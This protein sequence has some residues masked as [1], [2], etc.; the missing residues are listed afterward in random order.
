M[1]VDHT[2]WGFVEFLSPLGQVMHIFGRLTL[3]IMCFFIAEGYRHTSRLSKY[4]DRMIG[5]ALIAII[6]FYL[7]F[8]EEYEYRQNIIFDLL[9]ALLAL[10]VMEKETL[11]KPIRILLVGVLLCIS[12]TIGG[13]V[14]MPIVYVLVFYYNDTFKKKTFWFC[15]YTCLMEVILFTAIV[16]N[17]KYHFSHY[18][19]TIQ[20]R[21]YLFG[22][23]LALI[24]LYF[25]NGQKGPV[26][27]SEK[28][29]KYFFYFF[30]PAHFLVLYGIK[31]IANVTPQSGYIFAHFV[32]LAIAC[33]ILIYVFMQPVSRAQVGVIFFVLSGIMYIYGFILEITTWEV[34]SVYT[35]TK[36]QYFG[37]IFVMISITY[38]IQELTHI[39]IPRCIYAA[40]I[41]VSVFV[42]YCLFTYRSNGL[43]YK[44]ISINTTAGPFPRMEVNGYGPV[45]YL[46]VAYCALVCALV[47]IIGI[48]S[49]T[50]SE[51]LHKKRLRFLFM[52]MVCMW[53]AF[54][55]KPLNLTNGYEIPAMFIPLTALFIVIAL[56]RYS[57]LDSVSLDFSNAL[58]QGKEGILIIDR[59][60]K[61]LYHNDWTHR[62]FGRFSRLDDSYHLPYVEKIMNGELTE[63]KIGDH[64][65]EFRV[66]PMIESNHH[67][68]DIIWTIDL[69]QHYET[70]NRIR[71]ESIRDSLTG[72]HNRKWFEENVSKSL[73]A[74]VRSA[75]MIIDL[76]HFKHVN[77]NRGHRVGDQI[78]TI[79]A[80]SIHTTVSSMAG[81]TLYSAR[82]GGDEFLIFYV[83]Y[84]LIK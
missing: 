6:P 75:F 59:N 54:L 27:I 21:V 26:I 35:A 8:H 57:Y 14:I 56:V 83:F 53:V 79:L 46:F 65:Y 25:Y 84:S 12:A 37:E 32:A 78:L 9:V 23:M 73:S 2:A 19:W 50:Q 77:D 64:T 52:S 18:E 24:P 67:T 42:L 7:F 10:C 17:Q 34:S 51:P 33:L 72:L 22:F 44:D 58:Q 3:P 49:A 70:L 76:D 28:I 55:I 40:E 31:Q 11:K 30:Y 43:F 15:F 13:W 29:N 68:G 39:K 74:N 48:I 81:K 4:L 20:E 41:V 38:C 69:T 60:H 16:L 63:K 66:E 62:I 61:V 45:F 82:L 5:F 1:V 47:I 36:L 80:D 71:Q